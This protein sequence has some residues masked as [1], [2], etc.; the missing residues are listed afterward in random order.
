M[1]PFKQIRSLV[2][3]SDND[4]FAEVGHF[5]PRQWPRRSQTPARLSDAAA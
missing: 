2:A 1:L 3:A 4:R 5:L